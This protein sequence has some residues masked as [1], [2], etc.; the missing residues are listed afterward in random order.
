[1]NQ[2]I[3]DMCEFVEDRLMEGWPFTIVACFVWMVVACPLHLMTIIMD[4]WAVIA[5]KVNEP[6]EPPIRVNWRGP[7]M[8]SPPPPPP[9]PLKKK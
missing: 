2:K 8:T 7:P 6:P 4:V 3:K 9:P 5:L 1:M